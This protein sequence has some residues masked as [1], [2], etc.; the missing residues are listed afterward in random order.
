M[1][2]MRTNDNYAKN[3]LKSGL[4]LRFYLYGDVHVMISKLSRLAQRQMTDSK[5]NVLRAGRLR[6]ALA[7]NFREGGGGCSRNTYL[8]IFL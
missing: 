2:I 5:I 1:I 7:R 4:L 8:H 3:L 6:C